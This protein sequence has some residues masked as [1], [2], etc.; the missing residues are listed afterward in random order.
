VPRKRIFA[1]QGR[2]RSPR[3]GRGSNLRFVEL[4]S[5]FNVR[6]T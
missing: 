3:I 5:A 2:S 4:R 6:G 1:L